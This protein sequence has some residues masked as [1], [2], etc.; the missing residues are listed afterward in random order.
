[1]QTP[2]NQEEEG[3]Y[4]GETRRKYRTTG[5]EEEGMSPEAKRKQEI[6]R[7]TYWCIKMHA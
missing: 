5:K 3:A 6:F 7:N 2:H 1:M 4:G